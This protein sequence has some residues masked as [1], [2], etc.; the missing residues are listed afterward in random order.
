MTRCLISIY[1]YT[2]VNQPPVFMQNNTPCHTAK[3]IMTFFAEENMNVINCLHRAS[4]VTSHACSSI[5]TYSDAI[6]PVYVF[7]TKVRVKKPKYF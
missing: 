3:S 4:H 7:L 2:S 6:C 5:S 1:L